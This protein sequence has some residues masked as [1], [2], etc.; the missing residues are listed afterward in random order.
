MRHGSFVLASPPVSSRVTR[1]R[2]EDLTLVSRHGVP[3]QEK[4][5]YT[6]REG[7]KGFCESSCPVVV[8][9]TCSTELYFLEHRAM[10]NAGSDYRLTKSCKNKRH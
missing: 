8:S 6:P 3:S 2:G 7:A 1:P 9:V 4:E 10:L 5:T